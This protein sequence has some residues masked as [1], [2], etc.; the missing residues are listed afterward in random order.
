MASKMGNIT[1]LIRNLQN[2]CFHPYFNTYFPRV[3]FLPP[4]DDASFDAAFPSWSQV[5]N[6]PEFGASYAQVGRK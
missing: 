3:F 1:A 4:M 5:A 6:W 2:V